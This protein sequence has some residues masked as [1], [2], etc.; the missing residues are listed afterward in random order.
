MHEMAGDAPKAKCDNSDAFDAYT[1]L[2]YHF[3]RYEVS[4]GN[5]DTYS[6]EGD[7]A[8]LRHYIARLAKSSR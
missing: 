7:N 6:V 3:C 4:E 1:H 8:E 2:L 5:T